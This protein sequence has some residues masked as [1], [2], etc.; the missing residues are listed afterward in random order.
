MEHHSGSA[1][2]RKETVLVPQ[3]MS[4]E[5]WRAGLQDVHAS[6]CPTSLSS[7][8]QLYF[9][10]GKAGLNTRALSSKQWWRQYV[11]PGNSYSQVTWSQ[12]QGV[13]LVLAQPHPVPAEGMAGDL[14]WPARRVSS[15]FSAQRTGC[16]VLPAFCTK[17][18]ASG[19]YKPQHALHSTQLKSCERNL[20][21]WGKGSHT[22][23]VASGKSLTSKKKEQTT[24][25]R[26]SPIIKIWIRSLIMFLWLSN[27]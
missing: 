27:Q 3:R 14:P 8:S 21:T 23:W 13:T 20:N 16:K 24:G 2:W 26:Q 11:W 19:N 10:S 22:N 25:T 4:M 12:E 17:M 5:N 9:L 15:G 6:K 7:V 1:A 18:P